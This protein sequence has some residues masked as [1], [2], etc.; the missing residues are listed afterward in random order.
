VNERYSELT[1]VT[2][3]PFVD[4]LAD[5]VASA[6]DEAVEYG[7]DRV[8][9]RT[10]SDP[11]PIVD[12]VKT[13]AAEAGIPL[14][15]RSEEKEN[16]DWIQAY[17]ESVRPIEAGPF[18]IHPE[19]YA[20]KE[21]RINILINPALAFGSGHH[22]T[23]YSCLEAVGD[24]VQ[25]GQEVL[26]VG[27]GSGILALAARKLGASVDLCDT[28]PL[29][30]QSARENFALNGEEYREIWEGS[31]HKTDR[32][33]NVVIANIIADV[34]KAIAPQL[35]ARMEKNSLLIL[36]GILDKKEAIVTP[37]FSDLTLLERKQND[38]WV[39]LIYANKKDANG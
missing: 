15:V 26:D 1:F 36:S 18:Y 8:I 33:Y 23:T 4:L 14:E 27:C 39:T 32:R 38:E 11:T 19:W 3:A 24:Y 28:D 34:L 5:F 12:A 31:A 13:L 17:Q 37:A 7:S 10:E 25:A 35:K 20:P 6:V 30:V 16:V 29:A 21:D 22:A 9:L 2:D